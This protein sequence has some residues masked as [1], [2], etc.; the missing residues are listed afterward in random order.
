[1]GSSYN[2]NGVAEAP[3]AVS[4][5]VPFVSTAG[6]FSGKLGTADIVGRIVGRIAQATRDTKEK[7]YSKLSAL[8]AE[9]YTRCTKDLRRYQRLN[10]R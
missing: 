10:C 3:F 8:E 2:L 5:V 4:V 7:K 9:L 6:V 1:M